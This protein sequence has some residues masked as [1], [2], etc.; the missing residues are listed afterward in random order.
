MTRASQSYDY[1][2]ADPRQTVEEWREG[3]EGGSS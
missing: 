1:R 2:T 3:R